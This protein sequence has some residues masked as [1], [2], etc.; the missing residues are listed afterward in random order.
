[1]EEIE[2]IR[3]AGEAGVGAVYNHIPWTKVSKTVDKIFSFVAKDSLA[4]SAQ[5]F[6]HRYKAGHDLI[7]DVLFDTLPEKGIVRAAKQAGHIILTDFPTKMGIPIPGFSNSGIG[8]YLSNLGIPKGYLS[9][10]LLDTGIG[11]FTIGEGSLDLINAFSG[12]LEWGVG[13]FFDTFGEGAVEIVVGIA[14]RSPLMI[15]AGGIN[16]VAG[17]KSLYDY[18]VTPYILGIPVDA[19]LTSLG[20]GF[21][22]GT[23]VSL[24]F[25]RGKPLPEKIKFSLINGAKSGVFSGLFAVNPLIG[26]SAVATYT[27]FNLAKHMAT[28]RSDAYN[29]LYHMDVNTYIHL[30]DEY[31]FMTNEDDIFRLVNNNPELDFF[32]APN[33]SIFF[34][35]ACYK[36][37]FKNETVKRSVEKCDTL[38]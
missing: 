2:T 38:N 19:L 37:R 9:V 27:V 23:T 35:D 31:F 7:T 1:M 15:T 8:K 12:N 11:V 30:L 16:A 29:K 25:S 14:T 26:F 24:L 17:T 6:H 10:N 4:D 36:G 32:E 13:T 18:A 28:H 22:F 33:E 34:E 20:L 5:G 21:L 3:I